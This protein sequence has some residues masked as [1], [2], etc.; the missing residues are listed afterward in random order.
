MEYYHVR[1]KYLNKETGKAYP[2]SA[3]K[4]WSINVESIAAAKAIKKANPNSEVIVRKVND[5]NPLIDVK[6]T[7]QHATEQAL[8]MV[9]SNRSF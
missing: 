7:D 6:G 3:G 5:S 2:D 1:G 9:G 8:E 4:Y